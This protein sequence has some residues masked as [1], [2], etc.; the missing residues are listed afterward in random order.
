MK[1]LKKYFF[2]FFLIASLV[3][4]SSA[5]SQ[6][7]E[8]DTEKADKRKTYLLGG[9]G[10]HSSTEKDPTGQSPAEEGEFF[11]A[12]MGVSLFNNELFLMVGGLN[13]RMDIDDF[14]SGEVQTK[15]S[16]E[17]TSTIIGVRV[18]KGIFLDNHIYLTAS[19]GLLIGS[20]YKWQYQG[21]PY[22]GGEPKGEI[23]KSADWGVG[24]MF[25]IGIGFDIKG[26]N[27]IFEPRVFGVT[28]KDSGIYHGGEAATLLVGVSF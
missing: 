6:T 1:A 9:V 3:N 2:A 26:V 20:I 22:Y 5:I 17:T 24:G 14:Q 18:I 13:V 28:S 10:F 7:K 27:I 23:Q 8:D 15:L 21:E 19:A 4:A 11:L 25:S 12:E 16:S